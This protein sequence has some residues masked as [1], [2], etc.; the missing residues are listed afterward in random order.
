[1]GGEGSGRLPKLHTIVKRVIKE[2]SK[3]LPAYFRK[4]S[5]LALNGDR[6]A[7]LY[8]INRHLGKPKE[9]V[10]VPG[11]ESF[12]A[13]T[14]LQLWDLVE[15]RRAQLDSKEVLLVSGQ[16]ET[17]GSGETEEAETA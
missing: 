3:N 9:I 16:R 11:L 4:L 17:E 2:D 8:L 15:E 1:M 5:E 12:G 13:K 10:E 6:E 14:V 7:L